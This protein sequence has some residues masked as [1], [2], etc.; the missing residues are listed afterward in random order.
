[1]SLSEALIPHTSP[2][3]AAA[4]ARLTEL[5]AQLAERE[6][7]MADL[8]AQ[9]R[10]FEALYMH[11][12]GTLYAALDEWE[13]KIA[14]REVD[15]YDS[16]EARKRAAESRARANETYNA[17]YNVEDAPEE[18]APT[19]ALKALFRE[20]AKRIHPDFARDAEEQE[21]FTR[22]MARANAA[23]SRGESETLERML[24]DHRE[25]S[26]GFQAEGAAA[27]LERTARQAVHAE[28]DLA[29]LD[30]EREAL[31][32]GEIASMRIDA[33]A[34]RRDGRDLLAELAAGLR[35]KVSDAERRFIFIARQVDAQRS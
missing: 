17:A 31:L 25:I 21:H 30:S 4:R 26:L 11:R 6:L 19:A 20:V 9:L 7:A 33:E 18:F 13:A 28:R 12:V 16:A 27:E 34:A 3:L 14:E 10:A 2:E 5:R 35:D 1:V 29:A 23:Y 24:D 8:R 15:L 32:A 22:L